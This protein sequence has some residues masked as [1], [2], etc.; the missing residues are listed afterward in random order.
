MRLRERWVG[1]LVV[2]IAALMLLWPAV[3]NGYPLLFGDTGVYLVDGIEHHVSW[4]RPMF[5][6]LFMLPLHL[7]LT[8]WPVVIAQAVI[9]ATV[10]LG[11]M[12][13]F[14]PRVSAWALVPV[15]F[16]LAV[17]TSLPWFV[18]QL[19]PDVFAGLLVL[20]LAALLLL[21]PGL[22][23]VGQGLALLFSAGCITMHLSLL[24]ISLAVIV[25]LWVCRLV[26]RRSLGVGEVARGVAVP[27]L[28]ALVLIGTNALL[29][30]QPSMSPYGKIFLLNRILVDGPG[31]RAL[32]RECPRPDWTLCAFKDEIPTIVDEDDMLWGKDAVINRAGGYKVVA[33][34][35]WPIIMAAVRAEPW[36]VLSTALRNTSEQFVA[37]RT[38]DALLR[39]SIFNDGIWSSVFS[40]EEQ[41]RYRASRQYRGLELVPSWLQVIN[42]SVGA[43]SLV[44]IAAGAVR[45]LRRQEATGGLL[46]AVMMALLANAFV[47]GALSG[48]FDRYQSR[49]IWLAPF[50]LMVML[51]K[52]WQPE[53]I[54]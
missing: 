31:D 41:A 50:A 19:M 10:L 37:F 47:A 51:I 23:R 1:A 17:G 21:P 22:G 18:S 44:L 24:P 28:A 20:A 38:G 16:V 13:G 29:I 43:A 2:L 7:K 34:Q 46:A 48:V 36:T 35:A 42:V 25:T 5:Y 27:A 32:Q 11:T 8:M 30:G 39:P 49:F 9:A 15:I 54:S 53:E 45:A 14:L 3:L 12:R 40:P 33:P 26:T 4:P 6:G 52:R